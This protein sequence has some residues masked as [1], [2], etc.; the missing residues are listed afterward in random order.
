MAVVDD[1]LQGV[2]KARPGEQPG[3]V[4]IV[5][6]AFEVRLALLAPIDEPD[7]AEQA[8]RPAV[9]VDLGK[10]PFVNPAEPSVGALQPVLAVDRGA[11]LVVLVDGAGAVLPVLA[12]D[13]LQEGFGL[14]LECAVR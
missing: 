14:L 4:V 9:A 11:G 2:A 6:L 12:V 13:P 1:L 7:D 3:Q 10:G 5:H 8:V